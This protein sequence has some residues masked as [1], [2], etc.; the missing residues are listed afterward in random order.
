LDSGVPFLGEAEAGSQGLGDLPCLEAEGV[1]LQDLEELPY[2]A[3]V[4][5]KMQ[6]LVVLK[7][8]EVQKEIYLKQQRGLQSSLL[9][10]R[11]LLMLFLH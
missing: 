11:H 3:E 10:V 7:L 4:V 1:S 6:D 2:Q 9:L 8:L 5:V